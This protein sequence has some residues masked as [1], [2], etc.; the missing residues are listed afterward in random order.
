M[1]FQLSFYVV[2]ERDVR[3]LH[4]FWLNC[5][6]F[7]LFFATGISFFIF[8]VFF[9]MR[10]SINFFY[11]LTA[12]LGLGLPVDE[13]SRSHS[14]PPHLVG[15]LWTS[16]GP[17]AETS[18][19]PHAGHSQET[20]AHAPGRI[21]IRNPSKWAAANPHL[22]PPGRLALIQN[23]P[24]CCNMPPQVCFYCSIPDM[25]IQSKPLNFLCEFYYWCR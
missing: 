14:Y 16:D 22:R 15:L 13:V 11:G 4:T 20:G 21:R 10:S 5:G 1:D 9:G 19:W 7:F 3:F 6:E 24:C 23:A 2:L 8:A 12:L 18:T 25:G 17:I